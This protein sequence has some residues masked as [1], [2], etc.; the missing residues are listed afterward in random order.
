MLN[1]AF[2]DIVKA[3][4][5]KERK[6][7]LLPRKKAALFL[8]VH[9][10][11]LEN[12][13]SK[14]QPPLPAAGH[15][16]GTK[17]KPVKYRLSTL[18]DFYLLDGFAGSSAVSGDTVTSAQ[19]EAAEQ[20]KLKSEA[21]EQAKA[22]RASSPHAVLQDAWFPRPNIPY[23]E[24]HVHRM[25]WATTVDPAISED[26]EFP[27]FVNEQGLVLGPAWQSVQQTFDWFMAPDTDVTFQT[28]VRG[29]AMV[30]VNE[31][32]RLAAIN[33]CAQDAP[34]VPELVTQFRKQ[35]L[36]AI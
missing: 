9:W 4:K 25:T 16:G 8:G 22:E 6:A 36:A 13:A 17:G 21:D 12:R 15:S 23:S 27:F 3:F 1:Q 2:I 5:P 20:A 35:Q 33:D 19:I 34:E 14:G 10:R 28:W 26:A 18:L 11:T 32:E 30:W 7:T 31:S 24:A 29:L